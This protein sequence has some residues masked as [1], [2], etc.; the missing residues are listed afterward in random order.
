MLIIGWH[1]NKVNKDEIILHNSER[2]IT[3]AV[4]L[5]YQKVQE[6]LKYLTI[7]EIRDTN[8][9]NIDISNVL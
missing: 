5:N 2:E 7:S 8:L 6:I 1:F 4:K 9:M 3:S